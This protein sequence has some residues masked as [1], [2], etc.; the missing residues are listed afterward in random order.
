MKS[1]LVSVFFSLLILGTLIGTGC[2]SRTENNSISSIS[3]ANPAIPDNNYMKNI[4]SVTTTSSTISVPDISTS[5]RITSPF[6]IRI[7][8]IADHHIGDIFEINGTTNLGAREK[9]Y[10]SIDRIS[11][12][13][14]IACPTGYGSCSPMIIEGAKNISYG[15]IL[16]KNDG[17]SGN[18]WSFFLDA[19]GPDYEK[20][21]WLG[22]ILNI[23]SRDEAVNNSTEFVLQYY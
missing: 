18:S 3:T 15:E 14:P 2:L 5:S 13:V 4:S 22:F 1:N 6:W 8:P 21:I 19:S 10:Y 16:V 7:N 9:L 20:K 17:S 23:S 11:H 12:I